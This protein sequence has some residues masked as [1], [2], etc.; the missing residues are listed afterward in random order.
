MTE[1]DEYGAE[2][3]E[4]QESPL[5]GALH[6]KDYGWEKSSL[7]VWERMRDNV[8]GIFATKGERVVGV[9]VI[10]A[11][12]GSEDGIE[13]NHVLCDAA[14]PVDVAPYCIDALVSHTKRVAALLENDDA[15]EAA[16]QHLN[17]AARR[18]R[19]RGG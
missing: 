18:R 13:H 9:A 14:I 4:G 10:L 16:E 3:V 6:E 19:D 8:A 11:I 15:V 7:E 12:G 2:P 5:G 17:R 1:K